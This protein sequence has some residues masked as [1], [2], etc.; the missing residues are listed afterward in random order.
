MASKWVDATQFNIYRKDK[1]TKLNV[2]TLT[3]VFSGQNFKRNYFSS[4]SW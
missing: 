1:K 2:V 4:V 3:M